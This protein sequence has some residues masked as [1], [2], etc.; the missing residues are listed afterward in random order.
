MCI[1]GSQTYVSTGTVNQ[2]S[3]FVAHQPRKS[4]PLNGDWHYLEIATSPG[5]DLRKLCDGYQN[6]ITSLAV[7]CNATRPPDL[8]QL[9]TITSRQHFLNF[10]KKFV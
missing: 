1:N 10:D 6:V 9:S 4:I 2:L 3:N 7:T 8:K 5:N